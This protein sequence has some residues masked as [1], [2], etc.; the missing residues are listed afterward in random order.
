MILLA[1]IAAVHIALASPAPSPT[2]TAA[3]KSPSQIVADAL[4]KLQAHL[5]VA[6]RAM[7]EDQAEAL[8]SRLADDIEAFDDPTI[9]SGYTPAEYQQRLRNAALLDSSIVDQVLSG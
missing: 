6:N 5:D 2:S 1:A 3:T 7:G 9:I 8:G 4:I